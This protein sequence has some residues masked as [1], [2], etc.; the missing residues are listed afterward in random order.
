VEHVVDARFDE[1]IVVE[2]IHIVDIQLAH[3][4]GVDGQVLVYTGSL[5]F[6][7]KVDCEQEKGYDK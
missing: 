5:R 6:C 4:I 3:D 7:Y 2:G 1:V